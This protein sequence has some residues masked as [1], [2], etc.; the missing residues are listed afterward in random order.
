VHLCF[1][2]NFFDKV[3]HHFNLQ[4]NFWQSGA[5]SVD[6]LFLLSMT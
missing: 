4:N 3:I 5:Q 1:K 6:P 2:E